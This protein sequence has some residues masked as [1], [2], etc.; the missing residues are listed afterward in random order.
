[1]RRER[2]V[3]EPA[4]ISFARSSKG[5]G[6]T[7][8]ERLNLHPR[9]KEDLLKRWKQT[10]GCG[11]CVKDGAVELQGDHRAFVESQLSASGLKS[12]RIGG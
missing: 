9:L 2:P 10:L 12:R 7:R 8:V 11:G 4:R 6:L 1:M 5:C 3:G